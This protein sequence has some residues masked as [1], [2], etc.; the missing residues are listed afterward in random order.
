MGL[1]ADEQKSQAAIEWKRR[2]KRTRRRRRTRKE[3][4]ATERP[5]VEQKA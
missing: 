3:Q 1:S 5:Y 4:E 2:R